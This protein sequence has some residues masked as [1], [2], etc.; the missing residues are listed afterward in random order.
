MKKNLLEKFYQYFS[1]NEGRITNY[2][3]PDLWTRFNI[4]KMTPTHLRNGEVLVDP[5]RFF[6]TLI[7]NVFL[8]N[9]P[10]DI[11]PLSRQK[12]L[13]S[14]GD[15]IKESIIY[16]AMVRTSS[17]WDHDRS[18]FLEDKNRD[19]LRETGTFLKMLALLPFLKKMGVDVLYLLPVM[20]FSKKHK[21]GELG[22]PYS[23]Q[24]FFM[25]DEALKDDLTGDAFTIDEEFR[26]LIE[27]CHS[28]DI[29]VMIDIIPRTNA[30]DSHF[31][32]DHPD[33]FYWVKKDRLPDYG[34]PHIKGIPST[35]VPSR[36]RMEKVYESENT[37]KHIAMFEF[38]PR[39]K[40]KET[41]DKIK[42][43]DNLL[44]TIEDTFGLTVA[45]AFSDHINDPQ[46]PWT[47]V[48][49]FRLYFDHP[50]VAKPYI[51]KNTPPYIL[52]DSIKC[53]LHPGKKPNTELWEMIADIIPYY[54]KT[55]GVDGVRIDMG[56]ALPKELL[57][58]IMD[59]ARNSDPDF[60]FI[61]EEL[62]NA[63]AAEAKQKGYNIIVGNG[64]FAQ[65]R[66]FSGEC[67]DFFLKAPTY[68]LPLFAA[69]ET[70][71]SP[72]IAA[73]AGGETL[74]KA[75]TVLN[76]FMPNGVPFINC[77]MEILETQAMNLGLDATETERKRLS[78]E[79]PYY[80]KLALFDRYQLHYTYQRRYLIPALIQS[81]LPIRKTLVKAIMDKRAF[82][83]IDT[84]NPFFIG[85]SYV[86]GKKL[87]LIFG[88]VNPTHEENEHVDITALRKK[89][90]TST[91]KGTLLFSTNEPR[92][93]FTQFIDQNTLDIHLAPGEVKI[94]VI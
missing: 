6:K 7:K 69:A 1:E 25:L 43:S 52:F 89:T 64:F 18:G 23:V 56:H 86:L 29:R 32:K 94:V 70:H 14:G 33:W 62:E 26:L 73:R 45:P 84:P 79:D 51:S 77:G 13:D 22:S 46:P 78:Y 36:E 9:A 34:P 2:S 91:Q 68:A 57:K 27:A 3:V 44:E 49:F 58:M 83:P 41:F 28:L 72:R 81:V 24:D 65:P 82:A 47:D 10:G 20:T 90:K 59:R 48:T 63:N 5:H 87:Y 17:A 88:N 42:D 66:I 76:L 37:K 71:D 30:I 8:D 80:G 12:N 31:I 74:S 21:K 19:G 50:D 39:T 54:Q 67:K 16:S 40:D 75:L 15:W 92:R 93:P 11:A 35:S 55:F 60:A 85:L 4:D 38:D 61:A 53:N